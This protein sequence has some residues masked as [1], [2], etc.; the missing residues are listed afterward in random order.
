LEQSLADIIR[1]YFGIRLG[2]DGQTFGFGQI[3]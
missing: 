3:S 2:N 1:P